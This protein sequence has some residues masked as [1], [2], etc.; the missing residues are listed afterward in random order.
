MKIYRT[1]ILGCRSRGTAAARAYHA[2]PRTEVVALCDLVQDH[3]DTLGDELGVAAQFGDLDK[4]ISETRPDIVAIPTGTEFHY[5]LAMRVL[6]YGVHIDIEKPLCVDLEQADAVV[7][8]ARDKGSRIAV[9]HQGRSGALMQTLG[10]V[11]REGR[12]GR[13]RCL[14]G[15]GKNYYGGYGLMNIGTHQLNNMLKVAGHCRSV[16]AVI[17]T[18]N[19]P[20]TPADVVPSPSGMGT[21]AGEYISATLRFDDDVTAT[22]RQHRFPT[23]TRP[24]M[25]VCGTEGRLMWTEV[26]L[27]P[28][29]AWWLPHPEYKPDGT[30]DQWQALEPTIPDGFDPQSPALIDEY[31][32]VEEYVNALDE[33]REP[34]SS[35]VEGHHVVE[36]M[37]GAFESAAWSRPVDFPQQDRSHPLKRWRRENGLA[38]D[39]DPMPRAYGEWLDAEDQ[40]LGRAQN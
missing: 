20:I 11:L 16:V 18:D 23:S 8:K 15:Y 31:C 33:N 13:V 27:A 3:L 14:D 30:H 21:I 39:P 4:M 19:H 36:I 2:H 9:H 35:G 40:R 12:I 37:M 6:E 26:G 38:P 32:F 28:G 7:A 1:A 17:L 34:E 22:L 29:G 24:I 5:E 25:E 10:R